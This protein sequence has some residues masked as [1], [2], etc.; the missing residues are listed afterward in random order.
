MA[1][2]PLAD[3]ALGYNIFP[4]KTREIPGLDHTYKK[5]IYFDPGA[6]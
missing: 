5:A 6:N 2:T 3:A 4:F 1:L